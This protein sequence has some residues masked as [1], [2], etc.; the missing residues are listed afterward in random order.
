MQEFSIILLNAF[1]F[2]Q[3]DTLSKLVDMAPTQFIW[4]TIFSTLIWVFIY[5][6]IMEVFDNVFN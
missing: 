2:G 1:S 4:T 6:A 5:Q 3:V